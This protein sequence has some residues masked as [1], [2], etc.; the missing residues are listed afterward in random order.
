[1]KGYLLNLRIEIRRKNAKMATV[2]NKDPNK[3]RCSS[4]E[5]ADACGG[6][7]AFP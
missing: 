6:G 2:I 4:C 5:L 3:Q 7:S 1:V